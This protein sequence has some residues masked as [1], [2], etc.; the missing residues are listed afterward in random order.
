MPNC[1]ECSSVLYSRTPQGWRCSS[2]THL[3]LL[4]DTEFLRNTKPGSAHGNVWGEQRN[5][6]WTRDSYVTPKPTLKRGSFATFREIRERNL[7]AAL[8]Y[9]LERRF[10]G[11]ADLNRHY[12][13]A[14]VC[15]ELGKLEQAKRHIDLCVA[16]L[17]RAAR[18][19]TVRQLE[20]R[21][22][23]ARRAH[24]GDDSRQNRVRY[25]SR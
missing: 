14:E 5:P 16:K 21:I 13:V 24:F 12:L 20:E 15:L 17:A 3:E 7:S 22:T 6:G 8:N 1:P 11:N 4:E 10:A 25:Q 18:P 19:G 23:L 2:C 9:L